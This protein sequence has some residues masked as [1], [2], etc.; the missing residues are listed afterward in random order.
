MDTHIAD[1][2][3]LILWEVLTDVVLV[4]HSYGGAT[5]TCVADAI[6]DR[7][8]SI[9]YLDAFVP[10]SG[11][12]VRGLAGLPLD[13]RDMPPPTAEFFGLHGTDAEWVESRMTP[14]PGGPSN[15]VIKLE[16]EAKL[17]I[18]RTYVLAE[19]WASMDHF[20]DNYTRA[21]TEPGWNATSTAGSHD[22]MID[23]PDEVVAL[24]LEA[25]R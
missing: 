7:P 6:A 5:V 3:N 12:T 16:H 25:A 21:Q 15:Q 23:R 24:L 4:G 18:P 17:T 14:M 19:G 9:V 22:L 20:R 1:I 8:H 10:R 13:H 11:D 2:V